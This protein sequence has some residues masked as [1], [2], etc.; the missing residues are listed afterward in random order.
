MDCIASITDFYFEV[1]GFNTDYD[2]KYYYN[3][4]TKTL[5][6]SVNPPSSIVLLNE[7]AYLTFDTFPEFEHYSKYICICVL[8]DGETCCCGNVGKTES[9]MII[10][11]LHNTAE[12]L[13]F[14]LLEKEFDKKNDGHV[15]KIR[16]ME[17]L[18][19]IHWKAFKHIFDSPDFRLYI[20]N[21]SDINDDLHQKQ[22]Q[23]TLKRIE[24]LTL[25]EF[26]IYILNIESVLIS[27][28]ILFNIGFNWLSY[29]T[30]IHKEFEFINVTLCF[31]DKIVGCA[32]DTAGDVL[33][34][35]QQYKMIMISDKVPDTLKCRL[36]HFLLYSRMQ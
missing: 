32:A 28:N 10:D 5:V 26:K 11:Q 23:N 12:D 36:K 1:L 33:F 17:G 7:Q 27:D 4:Y 2:L 24:S 30:I 35:Y 31:N 22:L 8:D 29:E 16:D 20:F 6:D 19:N 18:S 13:I 15:E 34:T 21:S 14:D 3:Y 25:D 9:K